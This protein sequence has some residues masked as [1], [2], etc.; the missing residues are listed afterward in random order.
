MPLRQIGVAGIVVMVVW[1]ILAAITAFGPPSARTADLADLQQT[2]AFACG[3]NAGSAMVL[4]K[5]GSPAAPLHDWC[6]KIKATAA[7]HGFNP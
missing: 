6:E 5:L 1:G 2:V 4:E 7:A 3:H